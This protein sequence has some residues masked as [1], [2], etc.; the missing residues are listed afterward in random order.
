M[1]VYYDRAQMNTATT[2]TGA[3]T[4]TTAT[5]GYQTFAN[6]GVQNA[7]ALTILI[8]DSYSNGVPSAW[9]I[10]TSVYTAAGTSCTRVLR[11]SSTGALLNLSG[12]ATVAIVTASTEINQ[13]P[14]KNIANT[15]SATQTITPAANTEALTISG[16][17][18]TGSNASSF[19]SITG[20]W[21]TTG[22]PSAAVINVT[23]TASNS[24]ARLLD[25]QIAS[26]TKAFFSKGGALRLSADGFNVSGNGQTVTGNRCLV[27]F[28]AGS[29][30]NLYLTGQI[31]LSA[32][33]TDANAKDL[34]ICRAAAASLRLGDANAALP[35]AQTLGVQGSRAG[36]DS[37]VGGADFTI[38]SGIG[39]G[40]GAVSSL[41]LQ[42]PVAAASGTGAQTSTTG[43]TILN[44]T[45][46]LQG[47]T[48]ATLPAGTVGMTAYVT[49]ATAPAYNGALTGGGAVVVP[50]FYNG[51]AWVSA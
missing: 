31:G 21:N 33:A 7:D 43:L 13:F 24:S 23:D 26:T 30:G 39:T 5:T 40:T 10:S 15:F 45:A 16:G 42:S 3:V 1:T 49:D 48:V 32:N 29:G 19:A 35:V 41:I 2:G 12:S 11:A 37:N 36:T 4:L 25:L 9:E 38:R 44:G 50:V 8:L 28:D 17:S 51:T 14:L 22:T 27:M 18:L 34:F 6:A 46:K 20:T 47:Y